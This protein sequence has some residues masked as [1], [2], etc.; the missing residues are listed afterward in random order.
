MMKALSEWN[1]SQYIYSL[2]GNVYATVNDV[3]VA[4]EKN[5]TFSTRAV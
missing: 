4:T 3:N 5:M 2:V 1:A